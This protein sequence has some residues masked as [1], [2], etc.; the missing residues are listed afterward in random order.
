[1]VSVRIPATMLKEFKDV[2]KKD[3]YLDTSEGVRSII[4]TRWNLEKNPLAHQLKE[5]KKEISERIT[6]KNQQDL[7]EEL[8]KIKDNLLK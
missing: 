8:Q 2:S 4:R 3:H 1:M 6:I 7:I 5:L